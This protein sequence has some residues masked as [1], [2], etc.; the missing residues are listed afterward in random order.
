LEVLANPEGW[1]QQP[2][3][4]QVLFDGLMPHGELTALAGAGSEGKSWLT[5][6]MACSLAT[7]MPLCGQWAPNMQGNVLL[8]NAEDNSYHYWRRV[9]ALA[10]EQIWGEEEWRL[11]KAHV[12]IA[13]VA[14]IDKSM[15][16]INKGIIAAT[17]LA[18]RLKRA[19]EERD[20]KL[21]V[22]DPAIYFRA[23]DENDSMVQAAFMD[24]IAP[25]TCDNKCT[26]MIVQHVP[27]GTRQRE[28]LT[29]EDLR[30]S[31]AMGGAVRWA[32]V[33]R[34]MNMTELRSYPVGEDE[35]RRYVQMSVVK[36]NYGPV[37]GAWLHRSASSGVLTHQVL[38]T[39]VQAERTSNRGPAPKV[40]EEQVLDKLFELEYTEAELA[41][42][43]ECSQTLINRLKRRLRDRGLL[44]AHGRPTEQA[45][46]E[47]AL[48]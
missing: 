25:V 45:E 20:Y 18:K 40:T 43:L 24:A 31:T 30:G 47:R 32:A 26:V 38:Q 8:L 2:P 23:G 21:V 12:H 42:E 35:R 7:G 6:Q 29:I 34:T 13:C 46:A 5:L 1:Q 39:V 10:T 28:E 41:A 9:H 11:F 48:L 3:P 22:I 27:K 17:P 19:V 16:K 37:D 4:Q 33:M 44:D 15:T 14:G 36:S